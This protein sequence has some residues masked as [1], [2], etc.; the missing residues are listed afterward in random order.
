MAQ[1]AL[2]DEE[3]TFPAGG[4][5]DFYMEDDEIAALEREEARQAFGNAGIAEFSEVALAYGFVWPWRG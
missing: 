1:T 2:K 5:A 3:F 4:I